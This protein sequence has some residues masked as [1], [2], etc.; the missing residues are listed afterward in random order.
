M[1][2]LAK[3]RPTSYSSVRTS[4]WMTDLNEIHSRPLREICRPGTH[5]SGSYALT[6]RLV[7]GS[8]STEAIEAALESV[9]DPVADFLSD[10]PFVGEFV[11]ETVR[12]W[13]L[14]QILAGAGLQDFVT[15]FIA[16][17]AKTTNE[18][19]FI[20]LRHF[21]AMEGATFRR[22]DLID[23]IADQIGPYM[24]S[25]ERCALQRLSE[26]G[27][28]HAR[29]DRIS[30][31]PSGDAG[32]RG[33][34]VRL[35]ARIRARRAGLDRGGHRILREPD[36]GPRHRRIHTREPLLQGRFERVLLPVLRVG[37]RPRARGMA[38]S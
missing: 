22:Q 33:L 30:A 34:Q 25:R 37:E 27:R 9:I 5:D 26:A 4:Q 38:A 13:T 24:D 18:I 17:L 3:R 2:I 21:L 7:P 15:A 23:M 16:N 20:T 6:N 14:E 32:R 8:E 10:I 1:D 36:Q 12:Q 28:S 19:V 11:G 35:S 31:T 29:S